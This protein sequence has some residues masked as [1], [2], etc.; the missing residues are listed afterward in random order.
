MSSLL[1]S[2]NAFHE[3]ISAES[4][5][6]LSRSAVRVAL[7]AGKVLIRP[8]QA[9]GSVYFPETSVAVLLARATRRRVGAGVVGMEGLLGHWAPAHDL[10]PVTVACLVPGAALR[11]PGARFS[12]IVTRDPDLQALVSHF[13]D[14][15]LSQAAQNVACN[16]VHHLDRRCA[17]LLARIGDRTPNRAFE[18][19]H[20]ALSM[21]LGAE[22]PSITRV[23]QPLVAAGIV[24]HRRGVMRILDPAALRE[25]ACD[26]YSV[27]RAALTSW[28]TLITSHGA[29]AAPPERPASAGPERPASAGAVPF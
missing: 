12:A 27:D 10:L 22:R 9:V 14:L 24:E 11:I 23:L 3:A 13:A 29:P 28:A 16:A 2:D 8:N 6:A 20:E 26:C 1:G 19:T 15:M 25:A 4:R 7:P 17:R 21:V 5:A 18:I